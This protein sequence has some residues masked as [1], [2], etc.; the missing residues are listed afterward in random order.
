MLFR[1]GGALESATK[2]DMQG[3]ISNTA[4]A[5]GSGYGAYK[6]Y[7]TPQSVMPGALPA[8]AKTSV[9][10]MQDAGGAVM[11]RGENPSGMATAPTNRPDMSKLKG[12]VP[13]MMNQQ[14]IASMKPQQLRH[15]ILSGDV[16]TEEIANHIQMYGMS[17]QMYRGLPVSVRNDLRDQ[18]YQ[19]PSMIGGF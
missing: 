8:A 15:A 1:S 17:P 9:G 13:Q 7:T 18:G 14:R 12:G 10:A 3:A 19:M 4:N 2:G 11:G 5:V 16:T 6:Y